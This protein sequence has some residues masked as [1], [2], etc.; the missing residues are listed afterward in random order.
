ML[1]KMGFNV[2]LGKHALKVSDYTAGSPEE[3][4]EDINNFFKD[5]NIKAIISFIGGNH[6]NQILEYINF[7]SLWNLRKDLMNLR[8]LF[9]NDKY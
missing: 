5:S 8:L 2:E 3:R 4:A 6:S 9:E 1:E 7:K